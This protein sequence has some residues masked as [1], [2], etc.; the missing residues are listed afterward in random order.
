MSKQTFYS[1]LPR[2]VTDSNKRDI[3]IV[4]EDFNAK[5]RIENEGLEHVMD[6]M[7]QME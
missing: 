2:A 5:V 7:E 1:Q 4:M 3:K 6:D